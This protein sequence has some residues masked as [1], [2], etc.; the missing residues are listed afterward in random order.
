MLPII[1]CSALSLVQQCP[2]LNCLLNTVLLIMIKNN[3]LYYCY[4]NGCH[5]LPHSTMYHFLHQYRS[6]EQMS[7][8]FCIYI[9]EKCKI[10]CLSL[11]GDLS[12]L[13]KWSN[14]NSRSS[15][16]GNAK[17]HTWGGTTPGTSLCLATLRTVLQQMQSQWTRG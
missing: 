9:E 6:K 8:T 17:S 10:I 2:M 12:K 1:L 16:K 15:A 5:Q 14:K 7:H 13:E 3:L 4:S 11:Y